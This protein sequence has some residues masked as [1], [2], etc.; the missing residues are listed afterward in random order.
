MF[1]KAFLLILIF[2][3]IVL[4]VVLSF[5]VRI[6]LWIRNLITGR[7]N[8]RYRATNSSYGYDFNRGNTAQDEAYNNTANNQAQPKQNAAQTKRKKIYQEDEGEYAEFEEIE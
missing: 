3:L 6:I 1:A 7:D 5:L 8:N 2:A 4:A